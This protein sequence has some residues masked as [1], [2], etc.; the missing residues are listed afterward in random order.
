MISRHSH[1]KNEHV[2]LAEK[3]FQSTATAGFDQVRFIHHGLPEIS[4]H[5]VVT[6]STLFNGHI[7]MQWPF[8]IEAMTGG[9][10]ETGK[11]NQQLAMIAEQTGL[12][13]ASGSASV[14]LKDPTT[15]KSFTVI[16]DHLKSGNVFANIGA[17]HPLADA[18]EVIQLLD[19]DALEVHINVAQEMIMPEGDRDFNWQTDLRSIVNHASKP[20]IIKEVGFGMDQKTIQTLVEQVGAQAINISGRGGTNFALI[21]NFRR[22]H[23]DLDYLAAWG[24]TT[25]ESLLEA[26]TLKKQVSII[27]SGGIRTPLDITKA[28]ALGADAVG[29]A[30]TIL[31][32]LIKHGPE[33]TVEMIQD[34]QTGI[35][36]IMTMLGCRNIAELQSE[37]LLLSSDLMN[38]IHQRN[39][40]Y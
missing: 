4:A 11:L 35:V 9:S 19:A 38:Y 6:N 16:R 22:K 17:G 15:Q 14:A 28:I 7:K 2:S 1:R 34:W 27:A 5:Q 31:N 21:E 30:G 18:E 26:Q 23:K 8:Y 32:Q 40:K 39:I 13:M 37:R 33:Q 12:A 20:V 24:Q 25:V 29:V 36:T 3:F 10:P